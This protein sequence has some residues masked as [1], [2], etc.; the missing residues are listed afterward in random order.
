[1]YMSVFCLYSVEYANIRPNRCR[2]PY[3]CQNT[4]I[5]PVITA[6][7]ARLTLNTPILPFIVRNRGIFPVFS[8]INVISVLKPHFGVL[9]VKTSKS[10]GINLETYYYCFLLS[11]WCFW[12]ETGNKRKI[13]LFLP[14]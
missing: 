6:I 14:K 9:N 11:F 12:K 4:T 13:P 7:I 3:L 5:I 1:M 2:N 8:Q 10:Y